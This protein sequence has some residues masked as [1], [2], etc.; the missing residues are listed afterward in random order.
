[1]LSTVKTWLGFK[2]FSGKPFVISLLIY[3]INYNTGSRTAPG[4]LGLVYS[5][6]EV[7]ESVADY[8][9]TFGPCISILKTTILKGNSVPYSILS[10]CKVFQNVSQLSQYIINKSK[11]LLCKSVIDKV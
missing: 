2:E 1:M 7:S 8:S 4:T 9:R 3:S 5:S 6:G 10:N 11:T